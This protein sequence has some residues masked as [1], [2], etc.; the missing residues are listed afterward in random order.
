MENIR[1]YISAYFAD[2]VGMHFYLSRMMNID[3]PVLLD[4]AQRK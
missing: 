3:M 4:I 2:V 1:A